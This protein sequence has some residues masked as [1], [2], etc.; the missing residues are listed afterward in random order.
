METY[1][2]GNNNNYDNYDKTSI[3][4]I[5]TILKIFY[6]FFMNVARERASIQG[7]SLLLREA[8]TSLNKSYLWKQT[9]HFDD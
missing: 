7:N 8:F 3:Y 6:L 2:M 4:S 9:I 5:Y 1:K